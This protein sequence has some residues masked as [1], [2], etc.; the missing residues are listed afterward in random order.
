MATTLD[1][2]R[3]RTAA[4]LAILTNTLLVVGKLVAGI[5]TGSVSI[6]SEAAHSGVDLVVSALAYGAIRYAHRP[7]DRSQPYGQGKVEALT[8]LAEGVLI[9]G[10]AGL[11][12]WRAIAALI[13]TAE[14]A[15]VNAGIAV[16]VVA[17]AVNVGMSRYL[18]RVARAAGSPALEATGV[19]LGTDVLTAIGVVIGLVVVRVTG[20]TIVDPLIGLA[21]AAVIVVA[22]TRVLAGAVRGLMDANLPDEDEG[23]IRSVLDAHAED[24][25]EYHGLRA[26]HVGSGHAV[27]LHLVVPR[28]MSVAA[29]HDL[30]SHLESD[31]ADALPQTEVVIHVEP[32][33]EAEGEAISGPPPATSQDRAES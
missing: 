7:A 21:V 33:E 29:A 31:I 16:M 10:V 17:A 25:I 19:E 14:I 18:L 20:W 6:L 9:Y 13:G 12:V 24:F 3:T 30:S 27:D 15:Y 1:S 5:G 22:G 11:I 26:R 2:G 4:A 28:D 32:E 23:V 8:S